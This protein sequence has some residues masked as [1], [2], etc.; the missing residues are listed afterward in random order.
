MSLKA[1]EG[2]V[3]CVAAVHLSTFSMQNNNISYGMNID[4]TTSEEIH[5]HANDQNLL[6]FIKKSLKISAI[7]RKKIQDYKPVINSLYLQHIPGISQGCLLHLY[8]VSMVSARLTQ[9]YQ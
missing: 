9:F 4:G 6:L 1:T 3:V 7:K 2:D 5:L 8:I